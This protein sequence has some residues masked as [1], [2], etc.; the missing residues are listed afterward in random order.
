MFT[1]LYPESYTPFFSPHFSQP[2]LYQDTL[3][4]LLTLST[5]SVTKKIIVV[6]TAYFYCSG[7][8]F[9]AKYFVT[10]SVLK[11]KSFMR[12]SWH[13]KIGKNVGWKR[14]YNFLGKDEK[15]RRNLY[16]LLL[17]TLLWKE[18]GH[19]SVQC[20]L[21]ETMRLPTLLFAV[22]ASEVFAVL[23]SILCF[24]ALLT[25]IYLRTERENGPK[26]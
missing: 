12:I 11:V 14:V 17:K 24:L 5:N 4:K 15:T 10:E 3:F 13:L 7:P 9:A 6:R 8:I 20:I 1:H 21:R 2:K 16:L 26:F 19:F 23:T 22:Y 18:V 25:D